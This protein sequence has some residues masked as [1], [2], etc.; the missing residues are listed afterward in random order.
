MI[1]TATNSPCSFL[2]YRDGSDMEEQ[3]MDI[4]K[5]DKVKT[6]EALKV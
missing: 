2:Q 6:E 1:T 3:D 4:E 5:G